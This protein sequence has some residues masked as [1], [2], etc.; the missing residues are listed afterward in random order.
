[1][2]V[3]GD[4]NNNTFELISDFVNKSMTNDFQNASNLPEEVINITYANETT[5]ASILSN[6]NSNNIL[7]TLSYMTIAASAF[8]IILL[9]QMVMKRV[10]KESKYVAFDEVAVPVVHFSAGHGRNEL[11]TIWEEG[12]INDQLS[13]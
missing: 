2:A 3:K 12:N 11:T 4:C 10:Y 6:K 7:L 5:I 1:M 9:V 8:L 13:I